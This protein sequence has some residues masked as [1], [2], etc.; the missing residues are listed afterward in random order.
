MVWCDNGCWCWFGGGPINLSVETQ[1]LVFV[2][3]HHVSF[4]KCEIDTCTTTNQIMAGM[5][6]DDKRGGWKYQEQ[7]LPVS[8][9]DE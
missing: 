1:L 3:E 5:K 2:C 7:V 9:V 8:S 4:S 6:H